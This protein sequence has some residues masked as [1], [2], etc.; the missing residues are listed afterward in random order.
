MCIKLTSFIIT[1][2]HTSTGQKKALCMKNINFYNL[3][4][5][6]VILGERTYIS[7]LSR[8]QVGQSKIN[9]EELAKKV[10]G[11][12]LEIIVKDGGLSVT[13]D[14]ERKKNNFVR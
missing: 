4:S 14:C 7:S 1:H 6:S 13:L 12:Q 10:V 9:S 5:R 11:G 3:T 2:T 8:F